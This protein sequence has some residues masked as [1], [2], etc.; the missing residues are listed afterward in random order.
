[1]VEHDIQ[2]REEDLGNAREAV[3]E[4]EERM[5]AKIRRQEKLD[6]M[7]EKDFRREELLGKYT[8]KTLYG[9]DNRKFEEEYLRKLERNWQK[10]K[11]VFLEKKP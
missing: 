1:M 8:M 5:S 3:G 7:E 4:F 6:R 2:E 10:Q 9:Q 11:L